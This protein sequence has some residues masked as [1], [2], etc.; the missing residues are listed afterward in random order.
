MSDGQVFGTGQS[1]HP[2][3]T[4]AI[5]S[6][7]GMVGSLGKRALDTVRG[8]RAAQK[9]WEFAASLHAHNANIDHHYTMQ[10]MQAGHEMEMTRMKE[11]GRIQRM[12]V[13]HAGRVGQQNVAHAAGVAQSMPGHNVSMEASPEGGFKFTSQKAPASRAA[14]S[15]AQAAPAAQPAAQST[16]ETP[17]PTKPVTTRTA[18]RAQSQGTSKVKTATPSVAKPRKTPPADTSS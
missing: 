11:G 4:S 10:Q 12:N 16:E 8:D 18:A 5:K 6:I 13:S 7:G 15:K 1:F 2:G 3:K 9:Q 14:K 17:S